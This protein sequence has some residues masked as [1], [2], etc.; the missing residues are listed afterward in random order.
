M[1]EHEIDVKTRQPRQ[2]FRIQS[3]LQS[4]KGLGDVVSDVTHATGLYKLAEWYTDATGK[5]CGCDARR[6]KLNEIAP[7]IL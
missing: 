3:G 1:D 5:D 7:D 4:G 2:Q 6:E